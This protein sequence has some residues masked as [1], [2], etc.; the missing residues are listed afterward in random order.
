MHYCV[1]MHRG[2]SLILHDS[3]DVYATRQGKDHYVYHNAAVT[4]AIPNG[5]LT[6]TA[7]KECSPIRKGPTGGVRPD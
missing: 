4:V 6:L 7:T 1:L 3:T 5:C 2:L